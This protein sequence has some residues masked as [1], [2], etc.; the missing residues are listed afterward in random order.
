MGNLQH[1]I[2]LGNGEAG[3]VIPQVA[4]EKQVDLIVM[5]IGLP[6]RNRG[7]LHRQHRGEDP[8]GRGLLSLDGQAGGLCLASDRVG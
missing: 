8:A 3:C 4:H 6:N 7:I 2:H 5:G 1:R